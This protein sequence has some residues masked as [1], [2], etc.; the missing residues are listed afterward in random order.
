MGQDNYIPWTLRGVKV[1]FPYI[2]IGRS[3]VDFAV[4]ADKG[5][6]VQSPFDF[7]NVDPR[8]LD[9]FRFAV[10]PR[11]PYASQ[12]PP[13]WR[14]VRTTRSYEVWQRHGPTPPRAVLPESDGPGAVLDC[15]SPAGQDL[16]R[17]G[18]RAAVRRSPVVIAPTQLRRPGGQ[19][20][21]IGQFHRAQIASG[22][23]ALATVKLPAGR[24][25]LSLQY[26]SPEALDVT[27]GGTR[28]RAVPSLDGPGA[29]WLIG[30]FSSRG[31]PTRVD[32][33]AESAPPLA[34]FR[35]VL[36]GS[37]AFTPAGEHDRIVP[38]RAACGRYVDWY[39]PA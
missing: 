12:P 16:R 27:V 32:I 17:H 35:T 2:D 10:A 30:T 28:A 37:L 38:L 21:S 5:W 24:W 8:Y 34:T 14:L 13:N 26:V 11:T 4:R 9:R 20:V 36:L 39:Q 3:Q 6:N 29:F 1:A 23:D 22:E 18:G 7:D 15:A 33:H 25:T 31:G 19:P